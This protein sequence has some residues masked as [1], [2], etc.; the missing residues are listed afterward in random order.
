M[1]KGVGIDASL[2]A[3][4]TYQ[5]RLTMLWHLFTN[6]PGMYVELLQP[7]RSEKGPSALGAFFPGSEEFA[8]HDAPDQSDGFLFRP[9][10]RICGLACWRPY[11]CRIDKLFCAEMWSSVCSCSTG[12][13]VPVGSALQRAWGFYSTKGWLSRIHQGRIRDVCTRSKL[14]GY[15]GFCIEGPGPSVLDLSTLRW[16]TRVKKW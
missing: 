10:T 15:R 4:T 1:H 5:N 16:F 9:V 8:V 13:A 6:M 14:L 3:N 2:S 11:R 12:C 7:L